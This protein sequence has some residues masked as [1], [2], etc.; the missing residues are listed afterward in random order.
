M[1]A[2]E[3]E[4]TEVESSVRKI[5]LTEESFGSAE[6][7]EERLGDERGREVMGDTIDR[8]PGTMKYNQG[9]MI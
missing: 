5:E 4:L 3:T 8:M 7:T 2:E 6:S 9:V 1:K